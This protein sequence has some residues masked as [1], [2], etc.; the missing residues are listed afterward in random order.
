MKA[1][2][3]RAAGALI[4]L[5][6]GIVASLSFAVP[7]SAVG[8]TASGATS[9]TTT[10]V[11]AD[12]AVTLAGMSVTGTG[13]LAVTVSTTKGTLHVDTSTGVTLAAGYSNDSAELTFSGSV[14]QLNS[15]LGALTL[16]APGATKGQSATISMTARP[17]GS[18]VYSPTNEHFYEYV[19][20]SGIS[21]SD[22]KAAA[23][24]KSYGGQ[25][26]YLATVPSASINDLITS[27][28]PNALSVWLGGMAVPDTDGHMV[29]TWQDGPL[30]GSMFTKCVSSALRT[31]C[32]FMDIGSVYRNW[33]GGEPNNSTNE[34]YI[35][36]N[37]NSYN[38]LW[39]DL[40]NAFGSISGYVVEYGDL[41]IGSNVDFSGVA[42]ASST[43]DIQGV[44]DAPTGISA[45][46]GI[47]E[48]SV[49][50]T[51]PANDG[52]PDIDAY[53]VTASPGGATASCA[54]SPCTVTGLTPGSAYSFTVKAHNSVGYSSASSSAS[55]TPGSVPGAPGSG[56]ASMVVGQ[57]FS[58]SLA[59]GGYP[60][61]TFAV[62]SG[63]L[64]AGVTLAANGTLSG[65]PTATGAWSF[66]V[67]ATNTHGSAATS[68]AGSTGSTPAITSASLGT[69]TWDSAVDRT[70]TASGVP[71]ATWSVTA[72]A[73]PAGLVLDSNG[74]LHGTPTAAG[75]FAV[76]LHVSN[77][78]GAAELEFTGTV[79]A[80]APDEPSITSI[81]PGDGTL[82][83]AFVAPDFTGGGA[84]T[85]Y[86]YSLDG[87]STWLTRADGQTLASPLTISGLTNGTSY[88]VKLRAVNADAS[89]APATARAATP[90]K[91]ADAPAIASVEAG[92][93]RLTVTVTAPASD[94]GMPVI[95]YEYTLDGGVTWIS[96]EESGA[97]FTIYGLDNGKPYTIAVRA[98]TLA[99][100]GATSPDATKT[101]VAAPVATEPGS[102]GPV[103]PELR[104]GTGAVLSNGEPVT[105]GVAPVGDAFWISA[106][107]VTLAVAALDPS[108]KVV[109]R[110]K[111]AG[112][113]V[114]YSGGSVKVSGQGFLPGS[115][116]DVWMFSEP[117]LLGTVRVGADGSFS[118]SL[119]L[120]AGIP[121]GEH[122]IQANGLT[123]E[124]DTMTAQ[125]GLKIA[126]EVPAKLASTGADVPWGAVPALVLIGLAMVLL[127]RMR[128]ISQ[129]EPEHM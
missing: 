72:G 92:N 10:S 18:V 96:P 60:T 126:A 31:S 57:A 59:N 127:A 56:P 27:K 43:L 3:S 104:P 64:P 49:A 122:T 129:E 107:D 67:T 71:T 102:G 24:T 84:L 53:Q 66:E 9:T 32:N 2:R 87:G 78:H 68:Y 125:M 46:A 88:T 94:G 22:A 79:R 30:A 70:L 21:W 77:S 54:S 17:G 29:W 95:G 14:A 11:T 73:L 65:T 86:E 85:G 37:W 1:S 108:G 119:A 48:A 76:T 80:I 5:A 62:T 55:A 106:G 109:P 44:P 7:A 128:R 36:T 115:D 51:A 90:C 61:P 120:P 105:A 15:A 100:A 28:I 111:S 47:G 58:T 124:R 99:G 116:V 20:S 40:P 42:S 74:R 75:P 19:P 63:A 35:V 101:P 69:F 98:I 12:S 91:P 118:A 4:A 8:D 45:T 112:S 6:G 81:T 83:L 123:A 33:A 114:A 110:D 16:T 121:V 117:V 93:H 89:S 26:G 34:Y 25:T 38:G 50:F 103:L 52:G 23:A 41:P 13:T 82:V 39:N 97:V 113:F